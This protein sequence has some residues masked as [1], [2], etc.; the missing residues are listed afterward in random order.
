MIILK[1]NWKKCGGG[2]YWIYLVQDRNELQAVLITVMNLR[3]L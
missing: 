3:L 1:C 2:L